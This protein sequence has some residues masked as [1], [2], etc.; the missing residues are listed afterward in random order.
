MKIKSAVVITLFV[1]ACSFA[2]AQSFGFYEFGGGLYCNYEQLTQ[3]KPS[4]VWQG[5][6]NLSACGLAYNATIV[7]ISGKLTQTGNPAGFAV[8]GVAYADNIYDAFSYSYTG[9][10]WYM[11]SALKCSNELKKYGWIGFASVSGLVFFD[12]YGFLTCAIPGR[13]MIPTNG[14][15]IGFAKAR[16]KR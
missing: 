4:G 1:V 8:K 15:T 9:V 2:S 5:V 12:N 10:Q 11:V 3:L 6:D 7:G 14:P 13:D 16:P